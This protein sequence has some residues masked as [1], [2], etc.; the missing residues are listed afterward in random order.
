M[1]D[2]ES[3]DVRALAESLTGAGY[4]SEAEADTRWG[5]RFRSVGLQQYPSG[6][7]LGAD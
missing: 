4:L 7:D 5:R 1:P 2:A 3:R 6:R